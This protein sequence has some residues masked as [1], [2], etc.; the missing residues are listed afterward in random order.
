MDII[1]DHIKQYIAE[2]TGYAGEVGTGRS[3]QRWIWRHIDMA[4]LIDYKVERL[5]R[6]SRT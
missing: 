6:T 3:L 5:V 1:N 2:M 4:R